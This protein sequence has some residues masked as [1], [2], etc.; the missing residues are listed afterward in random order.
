M[1]IHCQ[2]SIWKRDTP[3]NLGP[4]PVEFDLLLIPFPPNIHRLI[5]VLQY[6]SYISVIVF[7]CECDCDKEFE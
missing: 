6:I 1:L 7:I 5:I 4:Q 3:M 2:N